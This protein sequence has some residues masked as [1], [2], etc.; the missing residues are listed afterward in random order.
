[1]KG[2]VEPQSDVDAVE[3]FD[4]EEDG[5]DDYKHANDDDDDEEMDV[6]DEEDIPIKPSKSKAVAKT[7]KKAPV[8]KE[9]KKQS[10]LSLSQKK[11]VTKK[12]VFDV[13][14]D[15]DKIDL[16]DSNQNYSN[17]GAGNRRVL[18]DVGEV[19]SIFTGGGKSAVTQVTLPMPSSIG[20]S[21]KK[22]NMPASFSQSEKIPS[23]KSKQL[24]A[25]WD[26]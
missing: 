5:Q 14:D 25:G 11:V 3:E 22:R 24:T 2:Y 17:S 16:W 7:T 15:D 1:M 26:D 18:N 19:D 10:G 8:V 21:T 20:I 12:P 23:A 13:D 6:D 4:E 9:T